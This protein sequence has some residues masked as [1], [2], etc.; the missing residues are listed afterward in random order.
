MAS[1]NP[2]TA[3]RKQRGMTVAQ[4]AGF[5][6]VARNTVS[7]WEIGKRKVSRELWGEISAKTGISIADIAGVPAHEPQHAQAQGAAE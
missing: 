1:T 3:Y 4:L 6:G 2:F 7:R 5:L